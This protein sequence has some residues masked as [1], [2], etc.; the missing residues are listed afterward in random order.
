MAA[1]DLQDLFETA[2]EHGCALI[3][4]EQFAEEAGVFFLLRGLARL[5]L[6]VL[7]LLP[8]LLT[9]DLF[10]H[11]RLNERTHHVFVE[12]VEFW[13]KVDEFFGH[14]LQLGSVFVLL[15]VVPQVQHK[16]YLSQKVNSVLG[17]P[18]M[19]AVHE[20]SD[21]L[22]IEETRQQATID[23]VGQ[24]PCDFKAPNSLLCRC[25]RVQ[26]RLKTFLYNFFSQ[27]LEGK[28]SEV[29]L[30]ELNIAPG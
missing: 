30:N 13:F 12:V 23:T 2:L 7:S 6:D 18:D 9:K 20:L 25:L 29:F 26:P 16:T 11:T 22:D 3:S 28:I 24:V 10:N 4:F 17:F 5:L 21:S 27:F 19:V 15:I 1:Q 14:S 8:H